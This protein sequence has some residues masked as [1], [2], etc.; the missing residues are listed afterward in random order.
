MKVAIARVWSFVVSPNYSR[1]L[2]ILALLVV[3]LAIPLTVFIAQKQQEIRQRAA[4][5]CSGSLTYPGGATCT[6]TPGN[7]SLLAGWSLQEVDGPNTC[8]VYIR[9]DQGDDNT[10]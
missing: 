8:N 1:T 6:T 7:H 9:G 4:G 10:I 3:V 5:T 2:S